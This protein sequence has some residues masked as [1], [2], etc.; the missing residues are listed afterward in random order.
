M[1]QPEY[2]MDWDSAI[3]HVEEKPFV[4]LPA[5]E[6]DFVITNVER[7]AYQP[8][9]QSKI[10]DCKWKA[11]VSVKLTAQNGDSTTVK[12][13]LYL[14]SKCMGML[15]QFFVAVGQRQHGDTSPLKPNWEGSIGATGRAKVKIRNWTKDDGTPMQSNEIDRFLD[16]KPAPAANQQYN[17]AQ[18]W[19]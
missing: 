14:H 18:G 11:E 10:K 1:T 19:Q 6:Y 3:E 15:C 2:A 16:P 17:P 5:G 9:S 12:N 8:G 4:V 7:K 13:N